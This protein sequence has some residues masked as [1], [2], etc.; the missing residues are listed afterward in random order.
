[1]T[2][3]FFHF[4]YLFFL[5]PFTLHFHLFFLS[6]SVHLS[7]LSPFLFFYLSFTFSSFLSTFISFLSLSNHLSLLSPFLSFHLSFI[8][9]PF[10]PLLLSLFFFFSLETFTKCLCSSFWLGC[11][12]R[13]GGISSLVRFVPVLWSLTVSVTCL[14][15]SGAPRDPSHSPLQVCS[16]RY[17][18][19]PYICVLCAGDTWPA[20]LR[21][22]SYLLCQHLTRWALV[23]LSLLQSGPMIFQKL[24]LNIITKNKFPNQSLRECHRTC[25][26]PCIALV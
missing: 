20:S 9:P 3:D 26:K 25:L 23:S 17:S 24:F 12:K 7:F 2:V 21:H 6:L 1:M 22:V 10:S 13:W 8:F 5:F 15:S 11:W 19:T 14:L 16:L 18:A 4:W